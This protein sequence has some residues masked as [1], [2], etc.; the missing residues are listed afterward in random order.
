MRSPFSLYVKKLKTRAV[1][2]ARFYNLATQD[3]SVTR[4]TGVPCVGEKGNR[5]RAFSE[6]TR[7]AHEITLKKSSLLLDYLEGFWSEDSPYLKYKR[8]VE[9]KPLSAYYV[10]LNVEGIKNHVK[11][12]GLVFSICSYFNHSLHNYED[13]SHSVDK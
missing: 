9:K 7:L 1:W 5:R 6:A 2:Y 10:K 4:S 12:R 8:I 3:Y 13:R 11:P